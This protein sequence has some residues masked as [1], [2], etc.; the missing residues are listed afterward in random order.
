MEEGEFIAN[1]TSEPVEVTQRSNVSSE[2]DLDSYIAQFLG[3][4]RMDVSVHMTILYCFLWF[5]GMAGKK[6]AKT[7]DLWFEW[8]KKYKAP[9][10]EPMV[11]KKYGIANL[12]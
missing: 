5:F 1:V 2:F 3:P 6:Y 10:S 8:S 7:I 12:G 11:Q 4:K 9:F